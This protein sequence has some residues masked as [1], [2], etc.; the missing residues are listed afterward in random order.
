MSNIILPIIPSFSYP[1]AS[2]VSL[3]TDDVTNTN[4]NL[5]P[6]GLMWPFWIGGTARMVVGIFS[7]AFVNLR[8]RANNL[9]VDAFP[10]TTL[11]LLPQ[12]LLSMGLPD[13][14]AG[15]TSSTTQ[16]RNQVLARLIA[17][18]GQS[19]QYIIDYAAQLGFTITI[20]E[21]PPPFQFG[22]NSF[23]QPY[24]GT[25]SNLYWQVNSPLFTVSRFQFGLNVF[26]DPYWSSTQN[27]VLQCEL[28]AIAP[29]GTILLF[30]YS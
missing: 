28:Q 22:F 10:G 18:G 5:F 1:S 30:N 24:Y 19:K 23:G 11:E 7:Q 2:L 6:K 26:G 15:P 20:T 27:L 12:W 14:C 21:V 3:S 4:V 16:Q 8:N 29:A 17:T 9:L 13:P 25:R